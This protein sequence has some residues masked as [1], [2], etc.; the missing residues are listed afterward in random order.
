MLR[1]ARRNARDHSGLT[2]A[3]TIIGIKREGCPCVVNGCAPERWVYFH[4]RVADWQRVHA[5]RL[6]NS[7]VP[8]R[9]SVYDLCAANELVTRIAAGLLGRCFTCA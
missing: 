7:F 3:S 4:N 1:N 2:A 9:I 6:G 8:K 5:L